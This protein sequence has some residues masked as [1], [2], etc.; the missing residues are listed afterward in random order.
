MSTIQD[1][2]PPQSSEHPCIQD[3]TI[4]DLQQRKAIGIQRYGT[5]LHGFNGRNAMVDLYQELIDAVQ[6]C[7]QEIYEREELLKFVD[8]AIAAYESSDWG[9]IDVAIGQLKDLREK[10]GKGVDP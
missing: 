6:Y 1:Q 5:A 9:R 3:L 10:Q 2:P 7:R 4:A 8:E